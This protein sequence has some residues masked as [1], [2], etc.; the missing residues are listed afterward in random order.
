[1]TDDRFVTC[2]SAAPAP[3]DARA[4]V[5]AMGLRE[6][7]PAGRPRVAAVMIAAP[8]GLAAMNG[9]SGG[10]GSPED[11]ALL[12]E[13][14]A[15]ADIVLVG[16]RTMR[17]ERYGRL[18]DADHR[19]VRE[20]LGLPVEV[21]VATVARDLATLPVEEARIFAEPGAPVTVWTG[22]PLEAV[23]DPAC[24]ADVDVVRAG[25]DDLAL[26]AVIAG[27]GTRYG[28]RLVVTEGGPT[29]LR[30]LVA[31][32]LLDDLILTVAP[33]LVGGDGPTLLGG[34]ALPD[35]AALTVRGLYRAGNHLFVHY[36]V[37]P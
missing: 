27:L 28:A 23:P 13:M 31:A 34:D 35:P 32:G 11:R 8:D 5:A 2:G 33:F 26:P 25:A 14:R 3:I 29:L 20:E 30:E 16:S 22:S 17:A 15:W 9:R 36:G 18:L 24:A 4:L 10:L 6:S 1:M 21:R 12:R 37:T 19:G 7:A